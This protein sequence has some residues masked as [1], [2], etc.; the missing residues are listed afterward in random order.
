[1]HFIFLGDCFCGES[2][3]PVIILVTFFGD[4]VIR[5]WFVTAHWDKAHAFDS[6][7][8][9]AV[10]HSGLD[11]RRCESDGFESACAVTVDGHSRDRIRF[12]S[13]EGYETPDVK[14]LFGFGHGVSNDNIVD[15]VFVE[16]WHRC[17]K[18][19]DGFCREFVGAFEAEHAARSLSDCCAVSFY[20]ICCFH[21]HVILTGILNQPRL[22]RQLPVKRSHCFCRCDAATNGSSRRK[23][24]SGCVKRDY[25]GKRDRIRLCHYTS[26][27]ELIAQWF[28]FSKHVLDAFERFAFGAEREEGF[29]LEVE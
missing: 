20:D 7:C 1:R 4:A 23:S 19:R 25:S 8:D 21:I 26:S 13:H 17:H 2:H 12:E 24:K 9:D 18:V 6:A 5:S 3:S 28:S 14:S 22:K 27:A 29:A 10:C 15:P 11:T 16:L